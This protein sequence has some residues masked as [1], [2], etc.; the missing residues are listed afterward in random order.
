MRDLSKVT[1]VWSGAVD[2]D[3][4]AF[5]YSAAFGGPGHVWSEQP[6]SLGEVTAERDGRG[7]G[8]LS[9]A[10][11]GGEIGSPI[12]AYGI[13]IRARPPTSCSMAPASVEL[14]APCS[15]TSPMMAGSK[16]GNAANPGIV[17]VVV[18]GTAPATEKIAVESP[19]TKG[20]PAAITSPK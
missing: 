19:R 10:S 2:L 1:I 17:W 15:E 16:M 6:R 11:A 18:F 8:F 14:T 20:P 3:L 13:V 9:T 7:H 12:G 4:H 5:E